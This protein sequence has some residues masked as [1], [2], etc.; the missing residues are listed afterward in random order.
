MRLGGSQGQSGC[1]GGEKILLPLSKVNIQNVLFYD[2]T[3]MQ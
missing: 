2:V 1:F 3:D